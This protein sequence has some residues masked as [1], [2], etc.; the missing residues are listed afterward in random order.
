MSSARSHRRQESWKGG[1]LRVGD[2]VEV[3]SAAEIRATLD[4]RGELE[5]LPFMPEMVAF[6][7]K[8]LSVHKVAHKICDTISRSGMRRMTGAV[9]LTGARCDGAAHGGM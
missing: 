7:G 2:M 6:C 8:R 4:D 3:R 5:S 1:S 9:Y